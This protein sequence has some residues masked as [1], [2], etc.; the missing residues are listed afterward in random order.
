MSSDNVSKKKTNAKLA[1]MAC[2]LA[3][4]LFAS[5]LAGSQMLTASAQTNGTGNSTQTPI[6][7]A[8]DVN[9]CAQDASMVHCVDG[10][11]LAYPIAGNSSKHFGSNNNGTAT[12]STSGMATTKVKPDRAMITAGVETNSTTAQGA[13]SANAE[14]M[15]DVIAALKKLGIGNETIST[16]NYNLYPVYE[17]NQTTSTSDRPC[18]EIYP[19]PPECQPNQVIV[20]YKATNSAT[21][22]LDVD[23]KVTAGSVI[24]TVVEAGANTVNGVSF[25]VS[26]GK[27]QEIRDSLIQ[28]AIAN[29][30]HRADIAAEAVGMQVS[31][32]QS[33]NLSDVQF[34]IYARSAEASPL[35]S[36]VPTEI[37]PGEQEVSTNVNII[38][39]MSG[40][41]ASSSTTTTTT[42]SEPADG[43]AKAVATARAFILSKLSSLGIQI[44]NELD[45]HSDTAVHVS[46]RE[47]HID[48]SILDTENQSH[49]GHIEVLDGKVSVATLDGKSIL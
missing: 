5:A 11:Q 39:Y 2:V 43:S 27:Q 26:S 14:I 18:I 15:A 4:G 16:S 20:G 38:F 37:L 35:A 41:N 9:N 1:I 48:Y 49:D 34:P 31:G 8:D 21:V 3:L 33:V 6:T 19:P 13:A 25:F 36:S 45:L 40:M 17:S 30:R 42:G 23:G 28:D 24:D 12:V 46:D 47:Y 22:E 29:A 32:V 10:Q 7:S 44:D